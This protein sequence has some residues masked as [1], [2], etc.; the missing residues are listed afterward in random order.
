MQVQLHLKPKTKLFCVKN[1]C[2]T[3]SRTNDCLLSAINQIPKFSK[4]FE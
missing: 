1:E 2:T 4:Y 3:H